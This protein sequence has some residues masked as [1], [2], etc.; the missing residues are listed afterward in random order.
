MDFDRERRRLSWRRR[1]GLGDPDDPDELEEREELDE[2][3]RLEPEEEL[4]PLEEPELEPELLLEL[5]LDLLLLLP[6][7][8]LRRLRILSLPLSFSAPSFAGAFSFPRSLG[9]SSDRSL[10]LVGDGAMMNE[11]R[12]THYIAELDN[13][14]VLM[15][16]P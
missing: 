11:E 3:E 12:A 9:L 2:P 7:E 15:T 8:L 14:R 10:R 5:E 16:F 4:E 13:R 1:L 6:V